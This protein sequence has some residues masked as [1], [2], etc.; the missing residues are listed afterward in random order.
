MDQKIDL[1]FQREGLDH[2]RRILAF[3]RPDFAGGPEKSAGY[4]PI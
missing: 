2:F 3:P 4:V 1:V